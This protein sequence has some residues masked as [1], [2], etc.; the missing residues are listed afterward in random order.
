MQQVSFIIIYIIHKILVLLK[1]IRTLKC[2]LRSIINFY[3]LKEIIIFFSQ[4]IMISI[5]RLQEY[6]NIKENT[7]KDVKKYFRLNELKT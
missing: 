7:T 1:I 4:H 5:S 6:K 2:F 3:F